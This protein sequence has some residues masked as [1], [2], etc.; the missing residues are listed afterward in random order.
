M[1]LKTDWARVDY[2]DRGLRA[3]KDRSPELFDYTDMLE[4]FCYREL[5][6]KLEVV[7]IDEAQDLSPLQWSMVA[8]VTTG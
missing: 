3:W 7:F 4:Q 8:S 5:A 2:V 1:P 6:P